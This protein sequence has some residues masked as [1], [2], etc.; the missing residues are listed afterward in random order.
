M[1]EC[2]RLFAVIL[3][4]KQGDKE[5]IEEIIKRFEPLIMD[6]VK[7]VDE[8]IE[9]ELRQ[10]IVEIIIKAVKKFEIK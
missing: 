5:A 4:A 8:E 2:E 9:E 3:K 10:D 7:G 6:S 1:E